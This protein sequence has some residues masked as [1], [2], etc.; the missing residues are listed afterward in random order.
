MLQRLNKLV[1]YVLLL[2]FGSISSLG[3]GL[4]ALCGPTH[5]CDEDAAYRSHL[6]ARA[7]SGPH[8]PAEH[9]SGGGLLED[10]HQQYRGHDFCPVCRLLSQARLSHTG[11][12]YHRA[13]RAPIQ[14]LV[15]TCAVLPRQAGKPYAPRGPPPVS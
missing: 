1:A 12:A 7:P 6:L 2:A 10:S 3:Y 14:R 11:P 8:C 5:R 13:F 4:H 15:L 9:A